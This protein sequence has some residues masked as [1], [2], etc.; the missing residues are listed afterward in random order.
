MVKT[1]NQCLIVTTS[2]QWWHANNSCRISVKLKAAA[3]HS[4]SSVLCFK[5]GDGPLMNIQTWL[6]M[7]SWIVE[8]PICYP[9]CV[10]PKKWWFYM[11]LPRFTQCL[12]TFFSGYSSILRPNTSPKPWPLSPHPRQ[13]CYG[14]CAP[15]ASFDSSNVW[16]PWG[17]SCSPWARRCQGWPTPSSFRWGSGRVWELVIPQ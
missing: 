17:R 3:D 1:T 9:I 4:F 14:W 13:G 15:S 12:P 6:M 10:F 11:V 16:S 8:Y 2:K 5:L 7:N